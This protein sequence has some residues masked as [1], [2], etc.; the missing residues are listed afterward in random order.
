MKLLSFLEKPHPFIFNRSS[1]LLPGII[2]FLIIGLLAPL[3]FQEVDLIHRLGF[4]LLF[5]FI[6]SMA[7]FFVVMLL[8]SVYPN[9]SDRWTVGKEILLILVVVGVICLLIFFILFYFQ[10]TQLPPAQLFKLVLINTMMLS[11][12]PV[13]ILVLFEQYSHQKKQWKEAKEMNHLL[14]HEQIKSNDILQLFGEN[15]KIELQLTPE[16][17]ICLKSDGNYIEV[18]Y[19]LD[20]LEKKLVRNRLKTLAEQLPDSLFFQCHK[21][22]VVNKMSIVSVEGNARNFELKLR[23]VSGSIPVSRAKSEELIRFLKG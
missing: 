20:K 7:V 5:G 12:F 21:S 13:V 6:A 10:L 4:A 16:E 8:K 23:G 11:V 1:V 15:G 9:Y 14:G 17:L 22:Y 18:I 3:G 2:T 19:G